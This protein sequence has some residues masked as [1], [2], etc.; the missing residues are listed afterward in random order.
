MH[1]FDG[2]GLE[3]LD[4]V[5]GAGEADPM[6]QAAFGFIVVQ[7]GEMMSDDQALVEGLVYAHIQAA[8]QFGQSDQQQAHPRF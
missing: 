4:L 7:R 8:S 3:Q 2:V 5:G 1:Y 6:L